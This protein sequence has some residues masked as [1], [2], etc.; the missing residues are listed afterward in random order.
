MQTHSLDRTRITESREQHLACNTLRKW[1][2]KCLVV[3]VWPM[4]HPPVREFTCFSP[5]HQSLLRID[6]MFVSTQLCA[7]ISDLK[8][9]A[10]SL[11]D[12]RAVTGKITI[13]STPKC[14]ARC[15]FTIGFTSNLNKSRL[16][17][18][19]KFEKDVSEVE[20]IM[21]LNVKPELVLK[22]ELLT[23]D[24]NHILTQ[25]ADYYL[26]GTQ[27][28]CLL[29]LQLKTNERLAN[30]TSIKSIIGQLCTDPIE[31]TDNCMAFF[32][33]TIAPTTLLGGSHWS[34]A[35]LSLPK[36]HK[37]LL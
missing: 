19:Q 20:N 35:P 33:P 2:S 27:P 36:L 23:K 31:I 17:H 18:F 3:D 9:L 6:Y 1:A 24:L 13:I 8:L 34:C 32:K 10:M 30:I 21:A 15:H 37:A 26:Q 25:K 14:A 11:S 22:R 12:H 29:A 16:Q 7:N 28:S 5:R 4:S